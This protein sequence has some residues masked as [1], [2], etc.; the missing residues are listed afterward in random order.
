MEDPSAHGGEDRHDAFEGLA[1]SRRMAMLPAAARWQLRHRAVDRLCTH[2]GPSR[3]GVRPRPDRRRHLHP[4]LARS[5]PASRPSSAS[6]TAAEMAGEGRQVM[7]ASHSSAICFGDSPKVAPASISGCVAVVIGS[8]TT[9]SRPL[10]MSDPASLAPTLPRPM[11]PIFM[12]VLLL[13]FPRRRC[14]RA[15]RTRRCEKHGTWGEGFP[16][17]VGTRTA[18]LAAVE[19]RFA[20]RAWLS[21]W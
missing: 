11:N 5:N 16:S 9:T 8:R 20:P 19:A 7:T 10:R 4:D 12:R 13:S 15:G 3:R 1:R 6:S 21:G 2:R 14:Y 17:D 18:T